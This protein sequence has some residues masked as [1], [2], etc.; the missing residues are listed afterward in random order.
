MSEE[1]LKKYAKRVGYTDSEIESFRESGH[2]IRQIDRLSEAAPLYTIVAEVVEARHC[3]SGHKV[4]QR[5]ILDVDGSF[6]TK[7]CPPRMCV[8]LLSQ[9][10]I[11]VALINERLSE[12]LEPNDFHFTRYVR[13]PDVGVEC[14]G[15]GE[16]KLKIEVVQRD[17]VQGREGRE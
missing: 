8:Y 11:P 3:N 16:V 13:C 1:T 15:Y 7:L 9:L 4:G 10:A 6:I 2:R 17:N 12:G 14:L 5:L